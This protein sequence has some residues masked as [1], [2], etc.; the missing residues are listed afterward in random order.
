VISREQRALWRENWLRKI[1]AELARR[2][3]ETLA[4]PGGNP[5]ERLLATLHQMAERMTVSPVYAPLDPGDTSLAERT[6]RAL[7]GEL[8]EVTRV[9][10]LEVLRTWFNDHGYSNTWRMLFTHR[11]RPPTP[12]APR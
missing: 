9:S 5:G 8:D 12:P 2:E 4:A 11:R 6:A 7:F 1:E 10:E 3:A